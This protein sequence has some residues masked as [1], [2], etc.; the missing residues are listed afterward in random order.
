MKSKIEG[1][2][3]VIEANVVIIALL[4][5][6]LP[7]YAGSVPNVFT[8]GTVAKSADVNANFSYLGD[9]SWD[10]SGSNLYFNG[11]N[12][13]IGTTAPERPFHILVSNNAA[14]IR[15]TNHVG[16]IADIGVSGDEGG[17]AYQSFGIVTESNH[18]IEIGVNGGLHKIVL[19]TD[20]YLG[21]D[22]SY[23][24]ISYP[25]HMASGAYVTTGGVWTNASSREYKENIEELSANDAMLALNDLKPVTFNY[26][27]DT[28]EHHIGFIAEDVPEIVATKDRKGLSPMDMVALLT[29]IVQEQQ[30]TIAELSDRV[31]SL[32]N[33]DR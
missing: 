20:G 8:S 17:A 2:K 4:F 30:K 5:L 23:D 21:V 27:T 15:M 33:Q 3:S 22:R 9:R 19:T 24:T 29:K 28:T 1:F 25:L 7:A 11:G 26:K 10:K 31:K 14:A 12:V 16:V 18:R 6:T 32:E 13:G